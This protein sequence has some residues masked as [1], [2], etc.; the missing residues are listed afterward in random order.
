MKYVK[1]RLNNIT[2]R[3]VGFEAIAK[4]SKQWGKDSMPFVFLHI[5]DIGCLC[6]LQKCQFLKHISQKCQFL[7]NISQKCQFLKN[8]SKK[9]QFSKHISQKCQFCKIV[10][11]KC[12]FWKYISKNYLFRNFILSGK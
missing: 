2:Y 7:K 6:Y 4:R 12:Q 5:Y 10:S 3:I 9:C 11:Q 8:I 1:H